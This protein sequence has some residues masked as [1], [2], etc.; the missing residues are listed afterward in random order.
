[1]QAS[2]ELTARLLAMPAGP[3]SGGAIELGRTRRAPLVLGGGVA[4]VGLFVLSLFVLGAPRASQSPGSMLAAVNDAP[5]S[6]TAVDATA[7]SD[8]EALD[9]AASAVW[10]VPA[11][12]VVDRIDLMEQQGSQ[13]LHMTLDTT[14]GEVRVLERP[15][16]LDEEA[17]SAIGSVTEVA[18]HVVYRVDG[19]YLLESGSCVVAVLGES[20]EAAE[21]VIAGLPEPDGILDRIAQG[22]HVLVG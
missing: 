22:W 1:M 15:G 9:G 6:A 21:T 8:V 7:V 4:V 3:P 18:G 5:G 12:M 17:A 2:A 20:D 10:S 11:D 19:W 16:A 14:L 13:A